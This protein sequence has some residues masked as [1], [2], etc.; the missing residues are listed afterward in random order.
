[1]IFLRRRADWRSQ[2]SELVSDLERLNRELIA[3]SIDK[4]KTREGME[5][6]CEDLRTLLRESTF[7]TAQQT[8]RVRELLAKLTGIADNSTDEFKRTFGEVHPNST[9]LSSSSIPTLPPATNAS[10]A[11]S[12]SD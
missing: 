6:I 2:K 10:A 8:S 9:A 11:C 4:I 12:I 5:S 7:K 3:E 1:M